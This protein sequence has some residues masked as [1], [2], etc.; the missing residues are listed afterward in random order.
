[1]YA[2]SIHHAISSP[3]SIDISD[4]GRLFVLG[5]GAYSAGPDYH[6]HSFCDCHTSYRHT[7]SN[8]NGFGYLYADG[9]CYT[10]ANL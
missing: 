2:F 4:P 1:L 9:D 8:P 6:K 5:P 7:G 3:I 10:Y